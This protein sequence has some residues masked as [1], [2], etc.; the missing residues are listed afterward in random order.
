MLKLCF[1]CV[2]RSILTFNFV[3]KHRDNSRNFSYTAS[4]ERT[5]AD[6]YTDNKAKLALDKYLLDDGFELFRDVSMV[7]WALRR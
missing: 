5:A 4:E 1:S 7:Q 2:V 6:V 3:S